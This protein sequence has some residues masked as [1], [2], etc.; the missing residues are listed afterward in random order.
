MVEL[1]CSPNAPSPNGHY[2]HAAIA[3]SFV[4]LSAQLPLIPGGAASM[5]D[6]PAAQMGQV[7]ANF[8]AVLSA[9]GACL[10]DL[11]SVTIFTTDLA[12]WPAIDQA[13]AEA[14]GQHRPARGVVSVEALHLGAL[15]AAQAI[16]VRPDQRRNLV[17]VG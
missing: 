12:H 8:A 13:Y 10:D 16:A 9:A 5:P 6:G 4:F 11:V 7:L 14:L 2:S 17:K 1:V 15:V 3:N